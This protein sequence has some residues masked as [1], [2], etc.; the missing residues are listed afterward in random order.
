MDARASCPAH[1]LRAAAEAIPLRDASVNTVVMT[2]TLC[3]LRDA[4]AGLAEVRRVLRPG[5]ELIFVEHGLAPDPAVARWQHR[6]DPL[7]A[8]I[9][10]HLD[11]PVERLVAEAS[12]TL[13]EHRAGY[14]RTGPR[15]LTF[16][17]EGV[18]RA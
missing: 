3:S 13:V 5:G 8:R 16:M 6:L 14:L 11:N 17:T 12:F 10:C 9:S 2:W 4:H 1:L 7:W 18:A 15:V